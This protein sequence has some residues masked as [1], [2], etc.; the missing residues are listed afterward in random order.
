MFTLPQLPYTYNA[1]EP[2]LD[3]ATLEIHHGKH[4]AAYVKNL[5]DVLPDKTNANL[6]NILSHLNDLPEA[7][8]IK[9][10]N[11]GGGH[12]N[13]SLFWT[14]MTPQNSLPAKKLESAITSAFG[15]LDTFKEK[16]TSAAV[17]HFGSGWAWLTA[18]KTSLNII[19]TPNQ[20]TP[21]SIGEI[22]ILGIDVW[23][24]AYYLK[25]QNRRAD[26]V[27][28]WWNV[29]NWTEASDRFGQL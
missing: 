28:A 26:F 19:T 25:F 24:H 14:Y 3:A 6:E 1:L 8:R 11:F 7:I 2:Y 17:S 12:Y 5:N 9:V 4:H 22:P 21:L 18:A 13:H 16:L 23:E 29:V 27:T 10:R 15:N 20:D